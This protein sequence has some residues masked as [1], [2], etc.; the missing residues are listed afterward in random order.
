MGR[1]HPYGEPRTEDSPLF[2]FFCWLFII[3]LAMP[4]SY[5]WVLVNWGLISN[6]TLYAS[7]G[8]LGVV[9]GFKS[10]INTARHKKKN[11][12]YAASTLPLRTEAEKVVLLKPPDK[13]A[14]FQE[15]FAEAQTLKKR[16]Y[17]SR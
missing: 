10:A 3:G 6:A 11:L 8:W 15:G 13:T 7:C 16:G 9:V 17:E 14:H 12:K 5:G 2:E 4:L 1:I